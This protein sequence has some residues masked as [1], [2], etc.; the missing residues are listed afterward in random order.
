MFSS[1]SNFTFFPHSKRP[2]FTPIQKQMV[3]HRC[4][5]TRTQTD[6]SLFRKWKEMI[7]GFELSDDK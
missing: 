5:H 2:R 6:V 7:T 4:M 3:K 1:T